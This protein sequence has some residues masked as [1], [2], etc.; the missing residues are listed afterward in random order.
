MTNA[1]DTYIDQNALRERCA[2]ELCLRL[3]FRGMIDFLTFFEG[4]LGMLLN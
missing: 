4:M 3:C 1:L 2:T